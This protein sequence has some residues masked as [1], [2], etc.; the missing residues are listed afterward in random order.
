MGVNN[1]S[2]KEKHFDNINIIHT[3]FFNRV[4]SN[5]FTKQIPGLNQL[6]GY[7]VAPYV[8]MIINCKKIN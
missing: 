6:D 5:N 7:G 2:D 8:E 4:K 3:C 1:T